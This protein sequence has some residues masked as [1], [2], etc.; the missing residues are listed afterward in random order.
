M[1]ARSENILLSTFRATRTSGGNI[2]VQQCSSV[3][4]YGKCALDCKE[5]KLQTCGVVPQDSV[6]HW[7]IRCLPTATVHNY[8]IRN[9]SKLK[10]ESCSEI[11]KCKIN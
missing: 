9:T 7:Q 11:S 2:H 1:G 8:V 6:S 5:L 3:S 10:V 4:S